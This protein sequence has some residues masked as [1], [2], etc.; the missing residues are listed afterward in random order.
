MSIKDKLLSVL[1]KKP[2]PARK[3][4]DRFGQI[5]AGI[6]SLKAQ[7]K[8]SIKTNIAP[9]DVDAFESRMQRIGCRCKWINNGFVEVSWNEPESKSKEV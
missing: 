3:K 1:K 9:N 2:E 7:G 4:R 6:D 8:T 5:V